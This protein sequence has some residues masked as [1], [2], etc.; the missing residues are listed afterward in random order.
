MFDVLERL[1]HFDG[2]VPSLACILMK[3]RGIRG[4]KYLLKTPGNAI[5]EALNFKM[6]L[7]VSALKNLCLWWEFQSCL[8]FI[9]S[10]LLKIFLTALMIILVIDSLDDVSCSKFQCH[11]LIQTIFELNQFKMPNGTC[12]PC[13]FD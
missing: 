2:I 5:S 6:S 9:I 10:L 13:S 7:E 4:G 11:S 3:Q 1:G 8:L 12:D